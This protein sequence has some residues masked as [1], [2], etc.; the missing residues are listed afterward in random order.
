MA[1]PSSS[2]HSYLAQVGLPIRIGRAGDVASQHMQSTYSARAVIM[3]NHSGNPVVVIEP[4]HS[5]FRREHIASGGAFNI[6]IA[7]PVQVQQHHHSSHHGSH[8]GSHHS[9]H[10]SS[11]H[12]SHHGSHHSSSHHGS[13]RGSHHHTLETALER[14]QARSHALEEQLIRLLNMRR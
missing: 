13:H 9:S 8:H 14:E 3:P 1:Y 12:G 11:H 5:Q 6:A 4:P 7:Q 2:S 10:H